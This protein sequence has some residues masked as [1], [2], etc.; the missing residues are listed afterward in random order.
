MV[1]NGE[2]RNSLYGKRAK[3]SDAVPVLSIV[4][5][6]RSTKY[7]YVCGVNQCFN[8]QEISPLPFQ[9]FSQNHV[10]NSV[11]TRLGKSILEGI[12][13]ETWSIS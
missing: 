2:Q 6:T 8:L 9:Y 10:F 11:V 13:T 7:T 5:P 4:G 3:Y 12:C 1:L